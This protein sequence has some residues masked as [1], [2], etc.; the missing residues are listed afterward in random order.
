MLEQV[1][2][3]LLPTSSRI[4]SSGQRQK[5]GNWPNRV[6]FSKVSSTC[7][8]AGKSFHP[9]GVH[10][11]TTLSPKVASRANL[12]P[13]MLFLHS[14][15]SPEY[16]FRTSG[17]VASL[18]FSISVDGSSAYFA[19]NGAIGNGNPEVEVTQC[20]ACEVAQQGASQAA[21]RWAAVVAG[22]LA[23]KLVE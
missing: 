13:S 8:N 17:V 19:Y 16:L 11:F 23:A 6:G 18:F 21:E 1:L 4:N 7:G 12:T 14:V 5:R 22:Q 20:S 3:G 9:L 15:C 10:F 2:L